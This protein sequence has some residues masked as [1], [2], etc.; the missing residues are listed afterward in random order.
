MT[1][2]LILIR[3]DTWRLTWAWTDS[4]GTPIDLTGATVALTIRERPDADILAS[5][6]TEDGSIVV[7]YTMTK[8]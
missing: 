1:D 2:V 4:S 6:S 5:A 7:S 8:Q 3:G